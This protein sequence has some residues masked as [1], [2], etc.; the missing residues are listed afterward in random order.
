MKER[1]EINRSYEHLRDYIAALPKN[2]ESSGD[3]LYKGR[4]EVRAMTAP[5][6]TEIVVKRFG[7]LSLL[8]RAIYSTL[9]STKARRAY[10][11]GMRFRKLGA[12]TPEPVACIEICEGG[13]LADAY[14]VSLK[15]DFKPLFGPLVEAEVF[16]RKLADKVARLMADLHSRG[17][18]HGDPNLN[19]ILYGKKDDGGL[20]LQL[21]DTN[22]SR[23]SAGELSLSS[24]L[25]N[26]MRVS[27]RRDLLR[28]VTEQY[29][30]IRGLDEDATVKK[31]MHYLER[32]ERNRSR[33][34]RLKD[35]FSKNRFHKQIDF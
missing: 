10:D 11:Y 23:F 20:E 12:D 18:M 7:R 28:Y 15:S 29:A 31:V 1:I 9:E 6:G 32:F 33:R 22:R 27:H 35:I 30:R 16:D 21:I 5:D 3:V 2:F 4:N 13:L 25:K 14:F 26:L 8:R 24:C 19:N 34:H 17:A